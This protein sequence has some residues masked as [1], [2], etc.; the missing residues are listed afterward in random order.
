MHKHIQE[1]RKRF[2]VED[3]LAV[4]KFFTHEPTPEQLQ[5]QEE[6]YRQIIEGHKRQPT[7]KFRQYTQIMTYEEGLQKLRELF[8]KMLTKERQTR[9][10]PEFT[11]NY[12]AQ[13]K[14]VLYGLLKYFINDPESPY[15]LQKGIYLYGACG[16]GKTRLM[17]LFRELV[18]GT[19]R[20]FHIVNLTLEIQSAKDHPEYDI[21]G[22]LVQ[23]EKCLDEF[24]FADDIINDHGN[25]TR[26]Y[27]AVIY[28]R[29]LRAQYG[30]I[31]HIISNVPIIESGKFIDFRNVDR[32][33]EMVT[34]VL[35]TGD[36]MRVK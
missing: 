14:E 33:N 23:G 24:G 3:Q 5:K 25:K 9:R 10:N 4:D 18:E 17:H 36:S 13:Q 35:F 22:T 27:D 19:S 1:L 20:E 6:Y 21:I 28:Q 2:G 16:S 32:F 7:P 26:V 31:T 8:A 15:D 30:K 11:V 12:T 29:H 34:P